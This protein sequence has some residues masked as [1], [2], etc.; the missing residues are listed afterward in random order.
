M[1]RFAK[2]YADFDIEIKSVLAYITANQAALRI[3]DE[4]LVA[5]TAAVVA[6]TVVYTAYLNQDRSA[7]DTRECDVGYR[8]AR[9]ETN[10]V[11]RQIK[12]DPNAILSEEGYVHL[13]IHKDKTTQTTQP[14]PTAVPAVAILETSRLTNKISVYVPTSEQENH[15]ALPD[16]VTTIV[17]LTAVT[18]TPVAPERSAY[19][20]IDATGRTVAD[21]QWSPAEV[22]QFGWVIVIYQNYKGENGPESH[23]VMMSISY[24]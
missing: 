14:R 24:I 7:A 22:N 2:K 9:N 16:G 13:Y 4:Q 1:P 12:A 11:Q 3:T 21:I 8:L 23:P 10:V 20:E 18:D 19:T 15:R 5:F 17:R 6:W